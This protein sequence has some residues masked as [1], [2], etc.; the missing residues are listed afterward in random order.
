MIEATI[1]AYL[2]NELNMDAVYFEIPTP[3]PDKFVTLE[4]TN[5]SK[6]DHIE[7]VTF[8]IMSYAPS[9]YEAAELDE[10]VRDAMECAITLDAVMSSKFGGGNNATD[11]AIKKY[12]YRSYF[13][14]YL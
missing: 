11:T 12:R 7:G 3:I 1:I 5:R 8:E 9:M 6:T 10:E 14:L 4:V 13:N 2:K